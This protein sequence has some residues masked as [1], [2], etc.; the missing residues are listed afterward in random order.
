LWHSELKLLEAR[1]AHRMLQYK[2][3]LLPK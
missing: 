3:R 1:E 2:Y